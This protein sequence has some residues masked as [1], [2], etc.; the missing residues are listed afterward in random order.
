VSTAKELG[1]PEPKPQASSEDWPTLEQAA[2]VA[3]LLLPSTNT[4]KKPE[5]GKIVRFRS[6]T[7][8]S[9]DSGSEDI[10]RNPTKRISVSD[11]NED[12]KVSHC[13]TSDA[14]SDEGHS[15]ASSVC[16]GESGLVSLDAIPKLTHHGSLSS[17]E[18]DVDGDSSGSQGRRAKKAS[19]QTKWVP[20]DIPE[21]S[22]PKSRKKTQTTTRSYSE[23]DNRKEKEKAAS[24][25]SNPAPTA[26]STSTSTAPQ[27][28][29]NHC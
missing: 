17:D 18:N 11:S 24:N 6:S 4:T 12:H 9:T 3:P 1:K 10:F 13:S 28:G 23:S 15:G 26:A 22:N 5:L 14:I 16:E 19:R 8:E 7:T 25:N 29:M 20:L 27:S 21:N 2:V